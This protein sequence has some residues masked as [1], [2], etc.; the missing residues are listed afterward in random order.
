MRS[1]AHKN[2]ICI[3]GLKTGIVNGNLTL[4]SQDNTYICMKKNKTIFTKLKNT[5]NTRTQ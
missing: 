2:F 3:I 5:M 1:N 4:I